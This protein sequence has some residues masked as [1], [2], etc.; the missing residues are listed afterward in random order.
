MVLQEGMQPNLRPKQICLLIIDMINELKFDGAQDLLPFIRETAR[1]IAKLKD[2]MKVE[3]LPIVYVNDNFGRWKSDFRT[4]VSRCL[5]ED[6]NAKSVVQL[7]MPRQDDYFVLKPK[8]SGFYAT[9]LD[10]LLE[11]LGVRRLILTGLLGNNCVLYTAAD[12]YMRGYE[13]FLPSDCMLSFNQ[14]AN[15]VALE[16]MK[17][18]L[19][20]VISTS[21]KVLVDAARD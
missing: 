15:R 1:N 4:L 2:R 6:E 3:Q 12:A 16:Q 18:T 8:H 17:G 21:D 14:E 7:L 20:A 10:L 5:E 9:P 19:N 11:H 13:I